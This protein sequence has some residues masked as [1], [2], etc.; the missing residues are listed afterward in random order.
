MSPKA[1]LVTHGS[2][3]ARTSAFRNRTSTGERLGALLPARRPR[4]PSAPPYPSP[5][6][7]WAPSR[8]TFWAWR[9]RY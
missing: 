9:R 6:R 1:I 4:H 8:E 3:L 2:S 5:R 7:N